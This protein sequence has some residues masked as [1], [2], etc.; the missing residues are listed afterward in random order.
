MASRSEDR[1]DAIQVGGAKAMKDT[2]LINTDED[3]QNA[4][5]ELVKWIM[6][7]TEDPRLWPILPHEQVRFI[8]DVC[9]AAKRIR[10]NEPFKRLEV[11]RAARELEKSKRAEGGFNMRSTRRKEKP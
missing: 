6:R 7:Q 2:Y 9:E 3:L 8:R 5:C 11:V 10:E 1:Q 4:Q